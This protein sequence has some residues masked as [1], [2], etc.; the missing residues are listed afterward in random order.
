ML[1]AMLVL[2]LAVPVM[3]QDTDPV[4]TVNELRDFGLNLWTVIMGTIAAFAVG[5]IAGIS[6]ALALV[7]RVRN[8]QATMKA[9]EGLIDSAPPSVVEVIRDLSKLLSEA[10]VLLEEVSDGEPLEK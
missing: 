10:G 7:S 3:A 6:G 8:D 4:G 5:G 9:I 1:V 2:V